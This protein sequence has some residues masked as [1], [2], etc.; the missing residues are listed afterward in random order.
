MK[1]AIIHEQ[2]IL[3][4]DAFADYI[5]NLSVHRFTVSPE[6]KWSAGQQ[7]DHLI[8][9]TKPVNSALALPRM[10]LRFWG[11]PKRPTMTYDEIVTEY[12]QVLSAGGHATKMY[13][14]A[15]I[16]GYQREALLKQFIQQKDRLLQLLRQW[17]E[18][19]LDKYLLP[20]PLMGK[21]TIREVMYFT[22][23]HTQHHL[24]SL[25]Q[26]DQLNQSWSDQLERI[27]Q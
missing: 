4:F 27:F 18:D 3:Q 21:I 19:D 7:L 22:I 9:S 15:I 14:P 13:M 5:Q 24:Q 20:H 8:K 11:A 26:R 10:L 6:G 17:H 2:L 23:Y 16:E 1:K 12:Q 25:K